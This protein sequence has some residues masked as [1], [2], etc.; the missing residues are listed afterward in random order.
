MLFVIDVEVCF[1]FCLGCWMLLAVC[2]CYFGVIVCC[3]SGVYWFGYWLVDL[4]LWCLV[5]ELVC[6][7]D[8]LILLGI[9]VILF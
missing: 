8:W 9:Q 1:V 4:D 2:C 5:F 7:V 6:G 3:G